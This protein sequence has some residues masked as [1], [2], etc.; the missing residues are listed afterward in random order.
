ML[1]NV[2]TNLGVII[3]NDVSFGDHNVQA[4]NVSNVKNFIFGAS[5]SSLF[6]SF[7]NH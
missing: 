4:V 3:T 6:P 5:K 7:D 2:Y 1:T